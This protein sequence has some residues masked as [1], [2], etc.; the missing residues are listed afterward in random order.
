MR[1]PSPKRGVV[2]GEKGYLEISNY[3][4]ADQATLFDTASGQSTF[5]QAGNSADALCYE[6]RHMQQAVGR[7]VAR[8][9]AL[10]KDVMTMLTA[11][12]NQ[13]G[14]KYPFE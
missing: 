7:G 3:P 12:R 2:A 8:E 11:V 6:V 4:R 5:I 13:W 10:T 9:L 14:M 1:S